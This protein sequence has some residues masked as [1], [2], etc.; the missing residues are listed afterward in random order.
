MRKQITIVI[1]IILL[2]SLTS[3]FYSCKK[4]K[5]P[6]VIQERENWYESFA[7]SII[8]YENEA[9]QIEQ[10]LENINSRIS[11]LLNNFEKVSKAREVTG[12]YLLKGWNNKI[13]LQT[14]GIYARI[15]ENENLEIIAT[16]AGGTFNQIEIGNFCSEVVRHDQALN[17]RH[18][19]FNTVFFT[20]G[21]AD[22]IA[23]YISNHESE[24]LKLYFVEGGRKTSFI[25]PLNEKEM[26]SK[27]WNLYNNQTEAHKLQKEL[28][29]CSRKIDTFRRLKDDHLSSKNNN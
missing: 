16:L 6:E 13:P 12:Y 10:C 29:I 18:P 3:S 15:N 14:T 1:S 22:T 27:T 9:K 28:A 21:K 4:L 2:L 25:L 5:T 24:N 19:T 26:I 11:S 7:D 20:G 17:Y 23:Q 8:Y